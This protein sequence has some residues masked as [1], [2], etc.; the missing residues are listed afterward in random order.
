MVAE[1]AEVVGVEVTAFD[2]PEDAG[3]REAL[4]ERLAGLVAALLAPSPGG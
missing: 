3:E 1:T 2:A 4:A